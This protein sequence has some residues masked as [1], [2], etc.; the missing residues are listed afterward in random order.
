MT[1]SPEAIDFERN[2]FFSI[3]NIPPVNQADYLGLA[4]YS[5]VHQPAAGPI[6]RTVNQS[7]AKPPMPNQAPRVLHV[8][9]AVA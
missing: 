2:I 1:H 7:N 8:T 6:N 4:I 9:N 5:A 3:I